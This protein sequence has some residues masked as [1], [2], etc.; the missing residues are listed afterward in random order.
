MKASVYTEYG[1]PEVL[2]IQEIATPV[3]RDNEVLVRV[4]AATANRTD[5][6]M[7]RAKPFIMRFF[8]G[9]LKP[10]KT[11]L[12][13]DFA[14]QVEAVGKDV[15]SFK[16]GDHVFGFDDKGL[17]THAQ[18]MV[19]AA[20]G[21]LSV[22]PEGL[23]F[24]A[25]AASLEGAHYAYNFLNKVKIEPGDEVLVYGATGAIGIAILQ[26]SKYFGATVTAVC[27]TK[28]LSL[29]KSLGADH[30]VDYLQTDFTQTDRKY[31]FIFDA[32]GKSSFGKCRPLLKPG[33]VY[34]SSEL[35]WMAQ[36]IFYALTTPMA[37]GKKV[38]F[39]IPSDCKRSILLIKKLT[40]EGHFKAVIDRKYPLEEIAAAFSYVE[41]GQKTG[42]VVILL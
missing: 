19:I 37:G 13:T 24:E 20:T 17:S 11:I 42:N 35:G 22:M 26:L 21:P 27:N 5:C 34:I 41:S 23:S 30:L 2:K 38:I 39:P 32:V 29:V 9:L 7:L 15:T 33:G 3:P 16:V 1:S 40:E 4:F 18:Y 36:N 31:N 8:T 28:N 25:A 6:A 12:G 14:G 10:A